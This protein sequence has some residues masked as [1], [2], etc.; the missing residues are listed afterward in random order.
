MATRQ[1]AGVI[2]FRLKGWVFETELAAEFRSV[3]GVQEPKAKLKLHCETRSGTFRGNMNRLI[4][5]L[6]LVGLVE[7]YLAV[8]LFCFRCLKNPNKIR[9]GSR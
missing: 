4:L 1:S 8:I 7:C 2:R 5:N 3:L 6:G 9:A